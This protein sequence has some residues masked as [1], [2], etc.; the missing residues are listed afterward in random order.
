[1]LLWIKK[2]SI[3]SFL[4]ISFF[5][6]SLFISAFFAN[7]VV[8]V[9]NIDTTLGQLESI[10]TE[11]YVSFAPSSGENNES[12]RITAFSHC[13]QNEYDDRSA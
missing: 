4:L 1:M 6:S 8:S 5:S 12:Y 7:F 10:D 9:Q 11:F 3:I 2:I 13:N